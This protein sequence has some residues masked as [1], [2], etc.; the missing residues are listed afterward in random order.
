MESWWGANAKE[1]KSRGMHFEDHACVTTLRKHSGVSDVFTR[2]IEESSETL[3]DLVLKNCSEWVVDDSWFKQSFSAVRN[4]ISDS[5]SSERSFPS[6]LIICDSS[7][8]EEVEIAHCIHGTLRPCLARIGGDNY[9]VHR[10]PTLDPSSSNAER[11]IEG[12]LLIYYTRADELSAARQKFY[13]FYTA[14]RGNVVPIVVVVKGLDDRQ[15]AYQW[16]EKHIMHDG[17][18]RLFSTFAP[19]EGVGGD[20]LKQR[21]EQELQDLI[22]QACLIRSERKVRGKQK[23]IARKNRS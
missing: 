4:M 6:T 8:N 13:A 19:A 5:G 23:R 21:A 9:Q 7:R 3:R 16:V 14:Y 12:D 2:R 1:F 15:A 11:K 20:S 10:V 22:R 18:G 17:A